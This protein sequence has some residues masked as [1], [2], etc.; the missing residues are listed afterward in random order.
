[1]QYKVRAIK[2]ADSRVTVSRFKPPHQ[3]RLDGVTSCSLFYKMG[4]K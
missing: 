4:I 1:M 2:D 3:H